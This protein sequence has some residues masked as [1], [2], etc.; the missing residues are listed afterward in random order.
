MHVFTALPPPSAP[1]PTMLAGPQIMYGRWLIEGYPK[2]LLF[3]LGSA[4][5]NLDEWRRDFSSRMQIPAP[6]TDSEMNDAIVLGYL[7]A[8]FL[9][10]V[11]LRVP[12]RPS[13]TV[14]RSSSLPHP[15]RARLLRPHLPNASTCI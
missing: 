8:W 13:R 12:P 6:P 14:A 9:G 3:D 11:C 4:W 10:E 1:R 5:S 15:H 2:V 7:V